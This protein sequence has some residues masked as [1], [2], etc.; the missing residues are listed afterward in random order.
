ML[1][2]ILIEGYDSDGVYVGHAKY[3]LAGYEYPWRAIAG[4]S[5]SVAVMWCQSISEA[6]LW[7]KKQGATRTVRFTR[8]ELQ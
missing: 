5:G 8:G 3:Q 7:L 4:S 1:P 6:D 2:V